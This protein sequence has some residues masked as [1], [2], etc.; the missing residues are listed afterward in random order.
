VYLAV[1]FSQVSTVPKLIYRDPETDQEVA[2]QVGDSQ[3]EVTI[4]RNPGNTLRVNNPSIS[5]RHARFVWQGSEVVLHDLDSSNGSYVNGNRIRS[6]VLV[7]GD[8][9]RIGEFPMDFVDETD[10]ATA[11]VAPEM[12]ESV[13]RSAGKKQTHLGGFQAQPEE[14]FGFQQA[15]PPPPP[16]ELPSF[17]EPNSPPVFDDMGMPDYGGAFGST[18]DSSGGGGFVLGGGGGLQPA[19]D[20]DAGKPYT[21]TNWDDDDDDEPLELEPDLSEESDLGTANEAGAAFFHT[22]SESDLSAGSEADTYNAPPNEIAL[23]LSGMGMS[24]MGYSNPD[25]T[26]EQSVDSHLRSMAAGDDELRS[27]LEEIVRERD[28]LVEMLQNRAGDGN[29]ASQL[30]IERL[31]KERDRLSDERRKLMQQLNDL[32]KNAEEGP[33]QEE[34]DQANRLVAELQESIATANEALLSVQELSSRQEAQIA[35]L[36][37]EVSDANGRAS[38]LQEQLSN[39]SELGQQLSDV[40]ESAGELQGRYQEAVTTIEDLSNRLSASSEE[41]EL[42]D[43]ELGMREQRIAELSEESSHLQREVANRDLRIDELLSEKEELEIA[44]D[45]TRVAL[46]STEE[47]L[48]SRPVAEEVSSLRS[49]LEKT[50]AELDHAIEAGDS[51]QTEKKALELE[52]ADVR[53]TMEALNARYSTIG[54]EFDGLRKERDELKEERVAFARETDYLQVERRRLVDELEDLRKRAK[55]FDKEG[56]RKKQIFEELSADLRKLVTENNS[57][58][59]QVK[60]LESSLGSAPKAETL[61]EL[62]AA[63]KAAQEQAAELESDNSDLTRELGKFA[64]EREA[65]QAERDAFQTEIE[66]LRSGIQSAEQ[67]REALEALRA[68]LET[69]KGEV[70]ANQAAKD[71]EIAELKT[72]LETALSAAAGAEEAAALK[73]K[74]EDAEV[75]LAEMILAK[76][77]LEDEVKKLKKK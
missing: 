72:E 62:Q 32:R 77:K 20:L 70:E 47:E 61:S 27:Q 41:V 36:Q 67:D 7:D 34:F 42:L 19:L 52:I 44:L 11:E 71:A 33:S 10:S 9:V 16:P 13:L 21:P 37:A 35:E 28:E 14:E 58:Q 65:L 8:R 3:P 43:R 40:Q 48:E 26:V 76:D 66:G 29:A 46:Q 6:Q 57:L 31:R 23:S 73:K 54:S 24:G 64:E 38:K 25:A 68:E 53:A 51:L 2:L 63:L 15:S 69:V 5:R 17:T 50:R 74:L 12:I 60:N 22:P 75:T 59:D 1:L 45:Q 4:G 39:V 55:T 18:E 49:E 30:Q 56:K